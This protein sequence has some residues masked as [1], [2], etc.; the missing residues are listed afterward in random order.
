MKKNQ[1]LKNDDFMPKMVEEFEGIK[2]GTK[3]RVEIKCPLILMRAL[4]NSGFVST[5][6]VNVDYR[7]ERILSKITIHNSIYLTRQLVNILKDNNFCRKIYVSKRA[8]NK[9]KGTKKRKQTT[10]LKKMPNNQI[11]NNIP[12]LSFLGVVPDVE[13]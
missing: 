7:V 12:R 10:R 9:K 5:E 11:T 13:D 4:N 6:T 3:I 1:E 2:K 8:L